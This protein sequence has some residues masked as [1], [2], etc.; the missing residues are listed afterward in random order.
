MNKNFTAE[1]WRNCLANLDWTEIDESNNIEDMVEIFTN[2]VT[3]A[4]DMVA[5]IKLLDPM[6]SHCLLS[7][8]N[9]HR[10]FLIYKSVPMLKRNKFYT[11]IHTYSSHGL[12]SG[13]FN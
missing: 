5:P 1:G 4:L 2:N 10:S 13:P 9:S 3:T 6:P 7:N 11:Y 8:A 12:N